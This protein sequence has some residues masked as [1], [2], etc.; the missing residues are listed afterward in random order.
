[1]PTRRGKVIAAATLLLVSLAPGAFAHSSLD[2]RSVPA[3][4]DVALVVSAPVEEINAY[5]EKVVLEVPDGFR[6]LSCAAPDGFKC[7]T[8]AAADPP[9]TLV[10]WERT[11]P[12]Q[13]IPFTSDQLPFRVRTIATPGRYAFEV[14]QFYSNGAVARW[15]GPEGSDH[16]APVLEVTAKG[17]PAVTNTTAPQHDGPPA[18]RETTT[19]TA[20][21]PTTTDAGSATTALNAADTTTTTRRAAAALA[22]GEAVDEGDGGSS[23]GTVAPVVVAVAGAAAFGARALRRRRALS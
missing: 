9:R 16:P 1:M 13:R 14:N 12:G 20:G 18:T 15:D 17:T 22:A 19:T 3:D 21:A 4:T 10:T 2:K 8:S 23:A 6:V 5:N 7:A 11:E